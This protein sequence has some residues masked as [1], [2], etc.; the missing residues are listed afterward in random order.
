MKKLILV[1]ILVP[2]LLQAQRWHVNVF[3]GIS[4]YSGDLQNKPF[5]LDQSYAAFGAGAQYDLT[6]H[7]S[8]LTNFAAADTQQLRHLSLQESTGPLSWMKRL[9]TDE[10]KAYDKRCAKNSKKPRVGPIYRLA[11]PFV[12]TLQNYDSNGPDCGAVF[13]SPWHL[14]TSIECLNSFIRK[15]HAQFSLYIFNSCIP[16]RSLVDKNPYSVKCDKRED[17]NNNEAIRLDLLFL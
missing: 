13:I 6:N 12:A 17:D 1:G 4:N 9:S 10:K 7:I 14:V 8:V 3:G 2:S 16:G 15:D 11:P 5:T